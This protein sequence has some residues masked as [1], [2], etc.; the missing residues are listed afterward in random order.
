MAA[1][2]K[3]FKTAMKEKSTGKRKAPSHDS[4]QKEEII[5]QRLSTEVSGKAQKY[6]H[7]GP[8]EFVP[9]EYDEVTL[10]NIYAYGTLPL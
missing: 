4:L 5:I 7:I 6:S 2:W 9:Y 10:D 1:H 8:R 3:N